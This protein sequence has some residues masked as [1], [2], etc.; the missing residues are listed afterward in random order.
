[1]SELKQMVV[2]RLGD[3]RY[4]LMLAVVERIVRAV[5]VMQL[6]KSPAIV[7]GVINVEGL[8]LPVL[9]LR[10]RAGLPDKEITPGDQF[11]IARTAQRRVV[12]VVDEAEGVVESAGANIIEPDGIVPGLDQVKGVI[13][14][15]DGLALIYDLE[16]FLSAD[17]A[18]AL[19]EA[20]EKEAAHG[21]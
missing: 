16:R 5:E 17:E 19:D 10:G 21:G 13:K 9:N 1:V 3:Q 8:I 11:L 7:I 20:M 2:F 4:A 15:E 14:F 12:L 6:P 18:A